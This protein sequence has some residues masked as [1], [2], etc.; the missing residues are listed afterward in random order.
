MSSDQPTPALRLEGVSKRYEIYAR[1]SDRL[2]QL[3]FGFAAKHYTEFWAL[4][5][6]SLTV[7]R[8]ATVGLVGANG[9][10]KSTLLQIVA[11]TL[12][13]TRGT[14]ER[15]G[16]VSAILELGAGFNPEF[17]GRE[18]ARLNA[19]LLGLTAREA[20]E[21]LGEIAA[22]ADIGD[23]FDRPVKTY[24]SG[25]Y[26]RLAFAVAAHTDP[27]ILIVDEALSVG[28][29]RFQAKCFRTFEQFQQA[30]RTILFV[31]HSVDLVTRHCSSAVLLHEGSVRLQGEPKDVVHEYLDLLF[32]RRTA[33]AAR[34]AGAS[35]PAA[36]KVAGTEAAA[37]GGAPRP[38]DL[39]DSGF[40]SRPG[41]NPYEY[42]WGDRS[43]SIVDYS[44][45]ST[46]KPPGST[47]VDA[48]SEL[49]LS[50]RVRFAA[51]CGVPVYGITV[52]TPDGVAVAGTNSMVTP[53]AG[54][55]GGAV[56]AGATVDVRFRFQPRLAAGDYLLSLGVA[57]LRDGE[58]VPLDRRYDAIAITVMAS[59]RTTGL[60][61]LGIAIEA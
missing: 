11:G 55:A 21:R 14:V 45:A 56:E 54:S 9:A 2:K 23:F 33:P 50:M 43:A 24:S 37:D 46:G 44:L 52:K 17:T 15:G 25:M 22:Y 7:P 6:V 28:D 58:I 32:G 19:A 18:N 59:G 41:Y 48:D 10:G 31:T 26:S 8:G 38:D 40:E 36:G 12:A 60:A 53:I 13:P 16:R 39:R 47:V 49:R 51:P 30:G 34:V 3:L 4:R 1:P 5:D 61:D 35:A 42:R 29:T 57:D 20:E 27:E